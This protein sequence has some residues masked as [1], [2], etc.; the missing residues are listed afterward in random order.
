[1]NHPTI[2]LWGSVIVRLAGKHSGHCSYNVS[3]NG[4]CLNPNTFLDAASRNYSIGT[5]T[6]RYNLE[7]L[8]SNRASEIIML[9]CI[10]Y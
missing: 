5:L 1:M 6:V 10:L 2:V 7:L 9:S 4:K 8:M 3:K